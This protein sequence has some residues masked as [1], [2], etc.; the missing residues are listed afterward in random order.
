MWTNE[1]AAFQDIAKGIRK[2]VSD[3]NG[4][5]ETTIQKPMEPTQKRTRDGDVGRRGMARTP[6][7]IDKTFLKKVV[8][9]YF[10]ER[11]GYQEV[12]NYELGLRAAFQNLLSSVAKHIGWS[13]A[14]EMTIGKIRPDGVIL[15]EFRI[16]R[17]YWEAKGPDTNLEKEIAKKIANKYPLTNTIFEDSQ[18]A[19]LYQNKKRYP[20]PFKL[21][22]PN[23]V[24]DLLHQFFTYV[25]PDIENFEEAVDE[26]KERIPEHALA[27]LDIIQEEHK[28]NPNFRLAFQNFAQLCRDSIDPHMDDFSINEML[29]QHL[30]T[31]RLFSTVFDN[32]DFIRRNVIAV[33]IEK[34][35]DALASRKFNRG[36]FL[37]TLDRFY[38]AIEQAA[39]GIESWSE[40]QEFLNTVY[41][42]FF[43]GFA[44]K[45]ADTHGIVYTPQ[46]IVDFM[47]ESVDVVLQQEFG[48]SL[49]TP[50]IKILDPATGT[51]NFIVN[52]I[53]RLHGRTLQEKYANDLFC[54]E[55]MLLPYYI[56]SLNIEHEYYAQIGQYKPFEGICFAD[57]LE[58]AE[59]KQLQLFVEENTERVKR[60]KAADI[61]VV[62]GNPP[63]NMGQKNESDNNKNRSYPVIDQ[64]I[65][66]TY[67]KD[68]KATLNNKLYD[69]YVKFFR[70]A[71]DRLQGRDGIV[72]Y[73]SNNSF[74]DQI[75]F[76]GMRKHLLKDFNQ[77]YHLDLH[78]NVRKNPKLSGTTHNIF[79]IQVGVGITI[80]VRTPQKAEQKLFYYR[81][82]EFWTRTDKLAFLRKN[83]SLTNIEW[84]ELRPDTNSTWITEGLQP[85]FNSFLPVGTKDTKRSKG[86]HDN[87]LFKM[88]SLGV[89][90]S[91]DSHAYS[92]DTTQL[93]NQAIT[94]IDIYCSAVDKLRRLGGKVDPA[95]L[96]DTNNPHIKWTRQV[97]AS[98]SKLQ[99]SQFD[100][101]YIRN[102]LYRPFTKKNLYFDDFWNEERYKQHLFFP[103]SFSEKENTAIIVS[104]HGYRSP[105]STLATNSISDLHLL[106]STDAFQCFPFYT[107]TEEGTARRENITDWALTQFQTQY[108]PQVTKWDIFHYI[109]AILHHPQ[110]RELYRE[111]LKRD[112]PHIPL[113][114]HDQAFRTCARIGQQLMHMHIHYETQEQYPLNELYNPEIPYNESLRVEKMKLSPDKT[115]LIYSKGL[116]LSGIPQTCFA[117]RLGNRSALEWL[118]DQYQISTDKRSGIES[119][120]NR[121]NDPDYIL[122]L[123]KQVITVSMKTVQLVQELNETVTATGWGAHVS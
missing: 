104:D 62:M 65:N 78:G 12:A 80:A 105:F 85:E 38:V 100:N 90:T 59:G 89:V 57:T 118:I 72:C 56:A 22:T 60:E 50:G 73:V 27:L 108:G 30:L 101:I 115:T 74:I 75:A 39:K 111:N 17:G 32:R 13:L 120:P 76:D 102:C 16:R 91:R 40:R 66:Q 41:E 64:R 36:E 24:M 3:L 4:T 116:T 94:F 88:Y 52:I 47:V 68:S 109:Y 48:Q 58:L 99:Y 25:E 110:Y 7:T 1:D 121:Q 87:A 103:T 67:V 122:R 11:K 26:F 2:V 55:I 29:I 82:P 96:I 119:D 14:P 79:S 21:H 18:T 37:K 69:P 5:K 70:W 63:Y 95:T 106:A 43:Q 93:I 51:G 113:V 15:D 45:Q 8:N 49:Q 6:Q 92:F 83:G 98:L 54:N 46:E 28:L 117:Y 107:Y 71:V 44:V 123:I 35:I 9:H 33:E 61:M 34:V 53:R 10:T 114:L 84:T 19:I 31:E 81:V 42:R 86:P 20:N 77:I 97:K 23:D 112:L